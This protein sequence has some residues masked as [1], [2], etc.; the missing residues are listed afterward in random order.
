M[1][2]R[3]VCGICDRICTT[4]DEYVEHV[5]QCS[6]RIKKEEAETAAWLAKLNAEIEEVKK[7]KAVIAKFKKEHPYE[8]EMNFGKCDCKTDKADNHTCSCGSHVPQ[9]TVHK[10]P[11]YNKQTND[12]E[13]ETIK[14]PNVPETV[15]LFF[16]DD[17][18][19][20]PKMYGK[21]NG[22]EVDFKE[23][24]QKHAENIYQNDFFK[25]IMNSL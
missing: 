3:Y 22:K 8:Y 16:E 11:K 10:M 2:E 6:E 25:W 9:T 5:K 21:V 23:A 18:N 15:E 20:K 4:L 12:V 17:G 14:T 1:S 7:A 13:K 19:G 24:A